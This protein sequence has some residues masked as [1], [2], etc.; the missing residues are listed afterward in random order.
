MVTSGLGAQPPQKW[1]VPRRLDR[2][3]VTTSIVLARMDGLRTHSSAS[4]APAR[5]RESAYWL[6]T[7]APTIPPQV[8]W[9]DLR[10]FVT[11]RVRV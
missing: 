6:K 4:T 1:L 5:G 7:G 11:A 3:D 10:T 2:E 9:A 8:L